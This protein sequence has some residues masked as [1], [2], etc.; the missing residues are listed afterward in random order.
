MLL[1]FAECSSNAPN[2]TVLLSLLVS[3]G[4]WSRSDVSVSG[5]GVVLFD[6]PLICVTVVCWL[7]FL[8]LELCAITVAMSFCIKIPCDMVLMVPF[9]E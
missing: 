2:A 5:S 7:L 4:N 9:A 3:L 1:S 8:C 6:K